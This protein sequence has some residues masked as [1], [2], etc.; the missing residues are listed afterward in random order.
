MAQAL[1]SLAPMRE[2]RGE[3]WALASTWP[4]TWGVNQQTTDL[5]PL[6]SLMGRGT[7]P[8]PRPDTG[9][10]AGTPVDSA[11]MGILGVLAPNL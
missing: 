9:L 1:G 5:S 10:R 2:V 6:L 4:G 11:H 7:M 3:F 8:P